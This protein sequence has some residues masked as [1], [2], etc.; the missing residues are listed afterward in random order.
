VYWDVHDWLFAGAGVRPA[1]LFIFYPIVL[2]SD[3]EG[4]STPHLAGVDGA[5][6]ATGFCLYFLA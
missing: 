2:S 4:A 3:L 1:P 6:G 5:A